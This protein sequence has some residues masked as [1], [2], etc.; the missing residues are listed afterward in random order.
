MSNEAAQDVLRAAQELVTHFSAHDT[1]AYFAS[2][3]P[4]ATFI[5]HTVPGF[6]RS[7]DAYR[8]LWQ[9]WELDGFRIRD[10]R[11]RDA[12]V[13]L[14]GDTAVFTHQVE[15]RLSL[16]GSEQTATEQETIIFHRQPDGRWLAV[17][18]HLSPTE[19]PDA[20]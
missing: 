10:C 8:N 19:K 6:I 3:A 1:E 11:S 12:H 20:L 7:R 5:F 16:G 4:S 15:T 17:H 9:Q 18:E 14:Y 13:D 2:F